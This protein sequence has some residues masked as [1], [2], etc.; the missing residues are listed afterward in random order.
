ALDAAAKHWPDAVLL[1][2][3]MPVM[4]GYDTARRLRELER[5]GGRKRCTIVA[6][7]SNDEDAIIRRALASGADHYQ[8]KPAPRETLLQLLG[9]KPPARAPKPAPDASAAD[10]VE[11]D[12][13]LEAALPGFL[14]S[15]REAL[16]DL[17]KALAA[18]DRAAAKRLA[19]KLAGSLN[20]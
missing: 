19:H 1:D 7:S 17:A 11:V 2:L 14:T 13:D 4:D 18:G 8:A 16:Q 6:I 9:D 20:L 15:R 3:E 5:E 10:P 12:A